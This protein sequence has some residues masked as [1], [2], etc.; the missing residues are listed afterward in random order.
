MKTKIQTEIHSYYQL[1]QN[2]PK[3]TYKTKQNS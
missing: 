3:Q 2:N 1:Q